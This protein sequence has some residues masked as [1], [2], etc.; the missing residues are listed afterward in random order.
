[1]VHTVILYVTHVKYRVVYH[2]TSITASSQRLQF[3]AIILAECS[4]Y[5]A[6][7]TSM[8]NQVNSVQCTLYT[9][10]CTVYS[11]HLC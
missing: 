3:M 2:V 8:A 1:M 10:H 9:V 6:R 4:H 5:P 7:G 11:V